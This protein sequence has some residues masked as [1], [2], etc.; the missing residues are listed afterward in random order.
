MKALKIVCSIVGALMVAAAVL[1]ALYVFQDR[2]KAIFES[3]KE[4][5]PCRKKTFAEE[6]SDFADVVAEAAE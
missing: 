5:C 3:L 4:K 1:T 6:F 2:I